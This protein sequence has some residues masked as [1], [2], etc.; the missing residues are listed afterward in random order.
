LVDVRLDGMQAELAERD[1]TAE[2]GE[3]IV[4]STGAAVDAKA[5]ASSERERRAAEE[6]NRHRCWHGLTLLSCINP[7]TGRK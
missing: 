4:I 7:C 6:R 5:E 1:F 2:K 3:I